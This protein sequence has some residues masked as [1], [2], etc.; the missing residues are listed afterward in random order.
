LIQQQQISSLHEWCSWMH[1]YKLLATPPCRA[2]E[3]LLSILNI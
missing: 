3:M 1:G 2:E